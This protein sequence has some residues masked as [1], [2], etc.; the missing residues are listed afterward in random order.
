MTWAESL[1]P[2]REPN[3]RWYYASRVVNM[4]GNAMASVALAFAV[5]H[6][7][8]DDPAAHKYTHNAGTWEVRT[9]VAAQSGCPW[10]QA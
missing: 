7:T 4:L 1:A 6:I 10:A 9:S 2:L 8:D 3:F 5:L